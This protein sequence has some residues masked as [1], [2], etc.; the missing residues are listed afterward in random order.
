M[1]YDKGMQW[2][3]AGGLSVGLHV[4]VLVLFTC[5]GLFGSSGSKEGEESAEKVEQV[6]EKAAEPEE[7]MEPEVKDEPA[8][9][10]KARRTAKVRGEARGDDGAEG[11][12]EP[13]TQTYVVKKGDHLSVLAQKFDCTMS[14]LAKLN[15]TT[16][17]KLSNL[18]VG[19]KIKVPA[20]DE[21]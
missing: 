11:V 21:D 16:K 1:M 3:I 9:K 17:E 5:G 8:A 14:D 20:Q 10:P 7:R 12:G 15:G 13:K 4:I 19:Q 6:A 2:V 18:K